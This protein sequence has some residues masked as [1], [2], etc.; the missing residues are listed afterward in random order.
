MPRFWQLLPRFYPIPDLRRYALPAAA[1]RNHSSNPPL[2]GAG[3]S[4]GAVEAVAW[5][6]FMLLS[7]H[8]AS[9]VVI[10][11]QMVKVRSMSD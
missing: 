10:F 1:N 2:E 3:E 11:L 6:A 4:S 7:E 9:M 5:T 8:P